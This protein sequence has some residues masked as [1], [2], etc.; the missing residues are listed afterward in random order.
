MIFVD[1]CFFL[2]AGRYQSPIDIKPEDAEED[3][4]LRRYPL[5]ISYDPRNTQTITN[6]GTS[7][8]VNTQTQAQVL[9]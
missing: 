2:V 5:K 9:K 1:W 3:N 7:V 4:A 6:T 8:K